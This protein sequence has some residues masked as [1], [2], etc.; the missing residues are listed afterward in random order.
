VTP[1]ALAAVALDVPV[2]PDPPEAR[3]WLIDEL[4]K[5]VYQ[6]AQ[7]TLF[8]RIAKAIADW[9]ASLQFGD[10]QGPPAFGLAVILTLVVVGIVVAILIFGVPRRN[11]RSAV[12]GSL[13]GDDDDRSAARIRQDAEA[14]AANG[15]FS[16]ALVEMFR[17]VARGLAERTIV[18]TTPGTTARDFARRAG[19]V[20]P[21]LGGRLVDSAAVFDGVRYLGR[22]GTEEQ[23]RAMASLEGALRSARPTLETASA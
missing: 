6:A 19:L 18:T 2:D 5:P 9:I 7:P 15:D 10:V 23:Y 17:A 20:F 22:P 4:A 11:R 8:D 12:A 14:A 13:F 21:D 3:E 16:A 1:L